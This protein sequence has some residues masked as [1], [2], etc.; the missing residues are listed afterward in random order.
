MFVFLV[1]MH[2]ISL[3]QVRKHLLGFC[4]AVVECMA[5]YIRIPSAAEAVEISQRWESKWS[6]P[7]AYGAIDGTHIPITAPSDGYR[8]YVN[9]K[10]WPSLQLQAVSDDRYM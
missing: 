4:S 6:F 1:S 8:D 9:R 5:D 2:Y 3:S 10:G 7:Q